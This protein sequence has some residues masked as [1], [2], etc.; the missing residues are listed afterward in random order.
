MKSEKPR[1]LTVGCSGRAAFCCA[2]CSWS[3]S[4]SAPLVL[5]F[6]IHV[7]L[8]QGEH[9]QVEYV[10]CRL[11]WPVMRTGSGIVTPGR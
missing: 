3:L 6:V 9:L 4:N 8:G 10:A 1:G 11:H 5:E 7:L 2:S